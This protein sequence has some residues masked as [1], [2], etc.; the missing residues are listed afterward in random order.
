MD[1][2]TFEDRVARLERASARAPGAYKAR[3]AALALVGFAIVGVIVAAAALGLASL[4]GIA[5]F[6]VFSGG[7][8]IVLLFK[9]LVVLALPLWALLRTAVS[10]LFTRLPAP[11]GLLLERAQAPRLFAALDDMRRRMRGPRFHRVLL[12]DGFNAAVMQRPLFGLMGW[13]RNYLLLGLPLLEA[14]GTGEAM[15][16]VAHEY[17]HLAG[18]HGRFGAFIY[19]LRLTWGRVQQLSRRWDGWLARPLRAL[20]DWYAP[21][22]NAYTFVLARANEYEADA[23]SAG[24][25]GAGVMADALKRTEI[26]GPRHRAFLEEVFAGT[27]DAP[28]PPDDLAA[29]WAQA[30]RDAPAPANDRQRLEAALARTSGVADTHPALGDRLRALSGAGAEAAAALPPPLDGPSAAEAWFGAEVARLRETLQA[31]WRR[32]VGRAW[33]ERH[34]HQQKALARIAHIEALPAPTA[35]EQAE[36]L[37]LRVALHPE[38]DHLDELVAFN[39]AH[40]DHPLGLFTEAGLRLARGDE[41][42]LEMMRRVIELDPAATKP[43]CECAHAWLSER[44][45]ARAQAWADRWMR[46][47]ELERSGKA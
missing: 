47:H 7:K 11:E 12:V 2:A 44:G 18:S 14:L 22:F 27:R 20:V 31:A 3:V 29:R 25:V 5:A 8:A 40:A 35:D 17:G 6:V 1:K 39:A 30:L 4:V 9:L 13:P 15:A 42:G 24:L 28:Q 38:I 43:A 10:A 21:Y 33:A 19:R 26:A 34:E 32:Q 36:R 37:R 45:D 46:R 41:R 23:A 16:V